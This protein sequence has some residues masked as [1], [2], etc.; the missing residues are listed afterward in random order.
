MLT[1]LRLLFVS[2]RIVPLCDLVRG[3]SITLSLQPLEL[4]TRYADAFKAL[5]QR[6]AISND[7]FVRTTMPEHVKYEA[8]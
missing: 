8:P 2:N 3:A 4:C 1:A 7:F 6:L 5:N